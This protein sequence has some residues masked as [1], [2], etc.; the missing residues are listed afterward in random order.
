MKNILT[1]SDFSKD[2]INENIYDNIFNRNIP[3]KYL[4]VYKGIKRIFSG[5]VKIEFEPDYKEWPKDKNTEA[6]ITVV[7]KNDDVKYFCKR[8]GKPTKIFSGSN[9][10]NF[11]LD[12]NLDDIILWING[13]EDMTN[14]KDDFDDFL[15]NFDEYQGLAPIESSSEK[16]YEFV[17]LD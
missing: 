8:P 16:P 13:Q 14:S 15:D 12:R 2:S 1:F 10:L 17:E 4:E 9:L 7:G 6:R 3:E 5:K 11:Y